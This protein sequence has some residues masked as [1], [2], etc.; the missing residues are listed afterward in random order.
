[1]RRSFVTLVAATTVAASLVGC[2]NSQPPPSNDQQVVTLVSELGKTMVIDQVLKDGKLGNNAHWEKETDSKKRK[3]AVWNKK[4][5]KSETK[6]IEV[7]S[8]SIVAEVTVVVSGNCKAQIEQLL[9]TDSPYVAPTTYYFDET[10]LGDGTE[11]PI[12]QES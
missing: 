5:R 1:M 4:L 7:K 3:V 12:T 2:G 8:G 11:V 6:V 9:I 10:W